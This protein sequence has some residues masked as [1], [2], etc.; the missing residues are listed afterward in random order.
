M[1]FSEIRTA[2]LKLFAPQPEELMKQT[3]E[4]LSVQS[5]VQWIK[6]GAE[7]GYIN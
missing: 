6:S 2:S 1:Q 7:T 4:T 3:W 5:K